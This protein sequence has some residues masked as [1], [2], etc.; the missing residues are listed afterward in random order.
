[1][2]RACLGVNGRR[3]GRLIRGANRCGDCQRALW[4]LRAATRDP[5]IK[6]LYAR[7]AWRT[8]AESVVAAAS[9]CA[10]CGRTDVKLTADHV[11]AIRLDPS[12]A[13]DPTNVVACCRSCQ[14]K[15]KHD[16]A[17]WGAGSERK[18]S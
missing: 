10:Y 16:P 13:L 15:R 11:V 8:L 2:L 3:C 18:S 12:R 6:R 7:N 4:R 9:G 5:F 17:W 1:M 14:E